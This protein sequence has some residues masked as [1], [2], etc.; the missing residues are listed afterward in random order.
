MSV[1]DASCWAGTKKC[2]QDSLQAFSS[3]IAGLLSSRAVLEGMFPIPL[4]APLQSFSPHSSLSP[5]STATKPH[6]PIGVG[7]GDSTASP[8][9]ALLLHIL[10]DSTG[11]ISTILFAH[12]FGSALEPECKRYRLL[13]DVLNDCAMLLDCLSPALPRGLVRIS[14][15]SASGVLRALCGVA[16]GAAKASLSVHFARRGNVGELNAVSPFNLRCKNGGGEK[17]SSENMQT[18]FREGL[19][20]NRELANS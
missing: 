13:A 11:R 5:S 14:V 8:T 7:V 6:V 16:A 19:W 12:R 10:Q 20:K 9:S 17:E 1:R 2:I 4:R 18:G 15:L 3:S